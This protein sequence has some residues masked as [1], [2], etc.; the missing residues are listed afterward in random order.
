MCESKMPKLKLIIHRFIA[1]WSQEGLRRGG[2]SLLFSS[3]VCLI[4][5]ISTEM[6]SKKQRL[7]GAS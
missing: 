1:E 2:R 3:A 6:Q 5:Q 4:M 7:N